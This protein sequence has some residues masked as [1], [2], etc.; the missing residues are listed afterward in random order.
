MELKCIRIV[1]FL[2]SKQ[3][4]INAKGV[5]GIKSAQAITESQN[6]KTD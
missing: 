1:S 6:R 5:H 3:S 2:M 4:T